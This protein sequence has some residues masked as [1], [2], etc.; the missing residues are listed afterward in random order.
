ML[1]EIVISWDI[2]FSYRDDDFERT[3]MTGIPGYDVEWWSND[4]I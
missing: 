1:N 3:R 2:N 4:G